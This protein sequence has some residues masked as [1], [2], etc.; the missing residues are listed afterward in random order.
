VPPNAGKPKLNFNFD[1]DAAGKAAAEQRKLLDGQLRAIR[2]FAKDQQEAFDFANQIV[3]GSYEDGL[4][5]LR[6]F[7]E[8]QAT[9]RD[10]G[11][12]AQLTAIDKEV[13]ALRKYKPSDAADR[14]DNENKIAEAVRKRSEIISKSTRENVLSALEEQ[15][16]TASLA[17]SYV[18]LIAQVRDLSGDKRGAASLRIARQVADA[19][20]LIAQQGGDPALAGDLERQLS[21]AADL[22]D[23]QERY[24]RLLERAR[25]EEE[26]L[27]LAAQ[28]GGK[29]ELE[30]MRSVGAARSETLQKL[31]L[32]VDK[33]NE[34]G[35]GERRESG[36]DPLRRAAEAGLSTR[37]RGRPAADEDP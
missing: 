10:A 4:S 27:M 7:Y 3:K 21:G 37:C 20:K 30:T 23:A 36:R 13:A 34:L 31:S 33:A 29:S 5:T 2:D 11:L 22:A 1:P 19:Q 17:R 8:S 26:S 32:M 14:A 18:D 35:Q 9:I 24:S 12:Q 16:A 15:R 6:Q 28:A 25:N